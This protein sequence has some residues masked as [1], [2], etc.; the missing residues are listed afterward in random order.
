MSAEAFRRV[1]SNAT[2]RAA[3]LRSELSVTPRNRV[4]ERTRR[5]D[6]GQNL[7]LKLKSNRDVHALSG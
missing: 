7:L 6:D 5:H 1:Q 2:K 4:N 3:R